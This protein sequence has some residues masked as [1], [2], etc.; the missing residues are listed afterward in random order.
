[1]TKV[2]EQFPQADAVM[3]YWAIVTETAS[4]GAGA[5]SLLTGG[6]ANVSTHIDNDEPIH[7][8]GMLY[9]TKDGSVLAWSD[10][11]WYP[12]KNTL[13]NIKGKDIN[14]KLNVNYGEK[15]LNEINENIIKAIE[16]ARTK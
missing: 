9:S 14:M 7:F 10:F 3:I 16:K 12:P 4:K 11:D 8:H 1:L 2:K 5:V 6:N 15:G 13:L